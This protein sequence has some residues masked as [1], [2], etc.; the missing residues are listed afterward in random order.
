[1]SPR[2]GGQQQKTIR[3]QQGKLEKK[4]DERT[5]VQTSLVKELS[6]LVNTNTATKGYQGPQL[7]VIYITQ[8]QKAACQ[9][10][11]GPHRCLPL[12]NHRGVKGANFPA[13]QWAMSFLE[14]FLL[15]S[16]PAKRLTQSPLNQDSYHQQRECMQ[17]ISISYCQNQGIKLRLTEQVS[18]PSHSSEVQILLKLTRW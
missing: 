2:D 9:I 10:S 6:S 7:S 3:Y 4:V 17:K 14:R 16:Q 1:M 15:L 5:S 8:Q 18:H 12:I 13:L 11:E